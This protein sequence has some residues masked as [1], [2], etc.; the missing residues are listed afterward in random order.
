[1]KAKVGGFNAVSFPTL[2]IK[3]EIEELRTSYV[4]RP[5][6]VCGTCG[7]IKGKP[8]QAMFFTSKAKAEAFVRNNRF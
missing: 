1:M 3:Y 2:G 5:E 8:W 6:N 4:V 7:W